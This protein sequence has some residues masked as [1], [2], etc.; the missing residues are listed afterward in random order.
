MSTIE[1]RVAYLEGRMQDHSAL[2]TE[3]RNGVADLRDDV[4]RRF[5]E[6]RAEIGDLRADMNGRFDDFRADMNRQLVGVRDEFSTLRADMDRRFDEVRVEARSDTR[7]LEDKVDR[8][9]VV[10]TGM[11]LTTALGTIGAVIGLYF[12]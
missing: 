9:F 7:R 5:G 2:W 4:N 12:R 1:E 10:L 6:V 3:L 11:V 8:H